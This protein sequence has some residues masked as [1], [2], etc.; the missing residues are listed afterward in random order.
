ML[1]A[2]YYS[3]GWTTLTT[4]VGCY[5][6]KRLSASLTS[7]GKLILI[8]SMLSKVVL[9]DIHRNLIIVLAVLLIAVNLTRI[10]GG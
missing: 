9:A 5:L 7:F 8:S 3:E 1:N 4:C 6:S 10:S 2:K